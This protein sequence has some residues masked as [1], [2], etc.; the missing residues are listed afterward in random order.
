[1]VRSVAALIP[2]QCG[3]GPDDATHHLVA[4]AHCA[5]DSQDKLRLAC[6]VIV[7]KIEDDLI[8]AYQESREKEYRKEI[9]RG[10]YGRFA[11]WRI[12]SLSTLSS[13]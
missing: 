7:A 2:S 9:C 6:D 12:H 8:E 13:R 5:V 3:A 1:M 4:C 10:P 11:A